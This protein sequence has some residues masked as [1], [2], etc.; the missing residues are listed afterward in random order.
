[1]V[2]QPL[3]ELLRDAERVL[4]DSGVWSPREDAETLAAHVLGLR[5]STLEPRLPIPAAAAGELRALV[6]RRAGRI[7][8]GHL[9][10]RARLGGIDVTVNEHVF[11]PRFPTELLLAWGLSAVEKTEAPVV[12]DLCTGSGAVALA[13][14]HARPDAAVHAV[15]L[16]EAALACARGNAAARERDGDTPITVHRGDVADSALLAGLDGRVD[17]VL[18]NPPYVPLGTRLLPEWGEHHPRT[19]VFGGADGLEVIRAVVDCAARMLRPG[20]ALAIEHGDAQIDVVPGLLHATGQFSGTE[21][22]H[23]QEN[24]PRYTT[25][26]RKAQ[27]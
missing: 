17:L 24:R 9:T 22:H 13:V 8:L 11:V 10:G 12:V 14:G 23:D 26:F 2:D 19:A 15:D 27:A 3:E 16:D 20:G 1:M 21:G 18:A 7:P 4:A 5:E 25:T 6:A